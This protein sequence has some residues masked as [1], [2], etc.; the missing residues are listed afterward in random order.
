MNSALK[1]FRDFRVAAT[2]E[3]AQTMIVVDDEASQTSEEQKPVE[4]AALKKPTR[5][6]STN[7]KSL[8][9]RSLGEHQLNSKI[10]IENAMDLGLICS[11]L[12]PKKGEDVEGRVRKAADRADIVCLDWEIHSDAGNTATGI[13]QEIVRADTKRNG[14]LRLIAIYTGDTNNTTI[15]DKI[16]GSFPED[17]RSGSDM[18]RKA[19]HIESKSGLRI[20]CL[21]KAHGTQLTGARKGNQ[22]SEDMLPSRL[23]EEFA[24]LAEGLLSNVALAT[25]AAIRSSTHH[26]LAKITGRMDGPYFHHRAILPIPGDAE[27]YAVDVVLSELKS[28]VDK[29]GVAEKYAGTFAIEARIREIADSK[30]NLS[31]HFLD[32][33]GVVK[34]CALS[35]ENLV[36]LVANGNMDVFANLIGAA[37]PTK[38]SFPVEISTFFSADRPTARAEMREF[39]ALTGVKGHPGSHQYAN[40]KRFPKLGLGTVLQDSNGNYLLC[41]QAS[42]DSVRIKVP[43]AFLFVPLEVATAEKPDHVVPIK[44][45]GQP[46]GYIGLLMNKRSY[47]DTVAYK[48]EADTKTLTVTAQRIRRR[49]GLFFQTEDGHVFRWIADLKQR[50]ALRTAQQLGQDLARLGFDEFEP[51][52]Q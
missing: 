31:L 3:F 51:F 25:I 45:R 44:R 34:T 50:R 14:R 26:V 35:V 23:Q 36:D 9:V 42:C 15:L 8:P 16:Y 21:F 19:L 30:T 48:F 43:R 2:R 39:A 27:E 10:L 37:K 33:A 28:V 52:R 38:K 32:S 24:N 12:R 41:L 29:Q 46:P 13:I 6:D 40:G 1:T 7:E 49:S 47:A 18:K 11:V 5:A 20:V 17:F 4:V 22:V